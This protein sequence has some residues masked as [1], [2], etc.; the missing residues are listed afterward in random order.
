MAYNGGKGRKTYSKEA[1]L[2]GVELAAI[3][4]IAATARAMDV[5]YDTLKAW[6]YQQFRNEY[7]E[8]RAGK[9]SEWR[10]DFAAKMEDL[11]EHY[12]DVEALAL[13]EA[14][15]QI[16][17]G[18]LE[19]KDLASLIKGMGA[20]RASASSVSTRARGEPDRLEEHRINVPQLEQA[21]EALLGRKGPPPSIEGHAVEIEAGDE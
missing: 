15:K 12:G 9:L 2:R 5:N 16:E 3:H 10:Q 14:R 21:I 7:S 17:G 11:T 8:F 13:E 1:R 19:A 4:G 20:A 18:D 6:C